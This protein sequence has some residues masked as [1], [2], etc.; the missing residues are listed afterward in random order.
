MQ[1]PAPENAGMYKCVV[2]NQFGEINANLALNIEVA[3]V[4]RSVNTWV[5]PR[6]GTKKATK[7][8]TPNKKENKNCKYALK[9]VLFNFEKVVL[10]YHYLQ[11]R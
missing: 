5:S 11:F 4:I 6:V 10:P 8:H 3:P 2:S 7:T 1:D 9:S